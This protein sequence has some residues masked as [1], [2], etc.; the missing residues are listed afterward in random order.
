MRYLM[1]IWNY[2]FNIP[3]YIINLHRTLHNIT[4]LFSIGWCHEYF[5]RLACTYIC[6]VPTTPEFTTTYLQRLRCSRQERFFKVRKDFLTDYATPGF[7]N[8]TAQA[9]KIA[10][11]GL[12]LGVVIFYCAGVTPD[13]KIDPRYICMSTERLFKIPSINH[14]VCKSKIIY[15]NF[16]C[17][18]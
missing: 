13:S 11:V 2:L 8:F 14:D 9:L 4:S 12:A 3:W 6:I 7:V 17:R 1:Q 18:Q 16:F 10:V 15:L 5:E